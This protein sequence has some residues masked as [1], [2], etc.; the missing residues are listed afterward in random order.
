MNGAE[1]WS[2]NL[3]VKDI[4]FFMSSFKITTHI[5]R[6]FNEAA[7]FLAKFSFVHDENFEWSTFFFWLAEWDVLFVVI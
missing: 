4:Q 7:Y 2:M 6:K 5:R 3:C 1:F